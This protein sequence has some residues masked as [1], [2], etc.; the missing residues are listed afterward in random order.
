MAM[1]R[2]YTYVRE[3]LKAKVRVDEAGRVLIPAEFRKALGI[4]PGKPVILRAEHGEL[5]ILTFPEAV[6]R[7]QERV[8]S[9]VP[10]GVSLSDEL[11]ADRRREAEQEGRSE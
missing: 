10:E 1:P 2:E 6:R 3:G 11:I 9:Y 4:E 5:R 7:V 8:A